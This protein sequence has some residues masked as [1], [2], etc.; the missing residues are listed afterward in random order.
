MLVFAKL[1]PTHLNHFVLQ[2]RLLR[3][4]V[5]T[6]APP[7][8]SSLSTRTMRLKW[9]GHTFRRPTEAYCASELGEVKWLCPAGL[10]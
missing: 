2:L 5:R 3:K 7:C 8:L 4:G 6:F 9:V 1:R 10:L